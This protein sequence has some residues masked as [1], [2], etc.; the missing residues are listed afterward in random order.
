LCVHG[1]GSRVKKDKKIKKMLEENYFNN[2]VMGALYDSATG[3]P[4]R[5]PGE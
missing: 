1:G 3:T 2:Q 5:V 4:S